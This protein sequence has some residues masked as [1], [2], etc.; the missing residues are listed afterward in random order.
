MG[1][2]GM[3]P[4]PQF[5]GTKQLVIGGRLED[6]HEAAKRLVESFRELRF[7]SPPHLPAPRRDDVVERSGRFR[8]RT[9]YLRSVFDI[10]MDAAN[11]LPGLRLMDDPRVQEQWKWLSNQAVLPSLEDCFLL[12]GPGFSLAR[13][14]PWRVGKFSLHC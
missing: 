11:E 2:Q 14:R 12:E 3:V 7:A 9:H 4:F 10:E 8:L 5:P 6:P 13:N 1:D